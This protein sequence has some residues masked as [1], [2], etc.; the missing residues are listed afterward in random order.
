M[1]YFIGREYYKYGEYDN[2]NEILSIVGIIGIDKMFTDGFS[3]KC[4]RTYLLGWK[5]ALLFSISQY[6]R[7]L[8]YLLEKLYSINWKIDDDGYFI[9]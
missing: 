8:K 4:N 3:F 1:M 2:K 7:N 5:I 6:I 9:K